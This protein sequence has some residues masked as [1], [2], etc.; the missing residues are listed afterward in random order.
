MRG[1]TLNRADDE[2]L[3]RRGDAEAASPKQT[4]RPALLDDLPELITRECGFQQLAVDNVSN[5]TMPIW[6]E[7][8]R[9]DPREIG[10]ELFLTGVT[11]EQLSADT[12]GTLGSSALAWGDRWGRGAALV[13]GTNLPTLAAVPAVDENNVPQW[14]Q[15]PFDY[16]GMGQD[17]A[18]GNFEDA[19]NQYHNV[20]E[21]SRYLM[22]LGW[23]QGTATD[24]Y[25][26][27]RIVP[28]SFG[29]FGKR[30]GTGEMLQVCLVLRKGTFAADT[31]FIYG[32]CNIQ[33]HFGATVGGG[34]FNDRK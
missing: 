7:L 32:H 19:D 28:R 9:I 4:A 1:R 6:C 3:L 27:S 16:P 22:T 25:P 18:A 5:L 34:Q 26:Y 31:G 13:I 2:A 17:Q 30:I 10:Q 11:I 14:I 12:A 20:M 8:M 33:L 24:T 21:R 23:V 29:A 15:A